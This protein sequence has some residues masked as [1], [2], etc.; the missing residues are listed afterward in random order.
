LHR[1]D[2]RLLLSA[3]GLG[4]VPVAPGTVGSFATA[5]LILAAEAGLGLGWQAAAVLFGLG[6]LATLILAGDARRPDGGTDPG[7]VVTDEV[8]G[9]SIASAA[10]LAWGLLVPALAAFF[11]FRL[12]DVLKPGYVGR[13][14]RLEGGLGVLA[15][16]LGAGVAAAAIVCLLGWSGTFAALS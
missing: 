7:W 1:R 3:L 5:A 8:A 9:Q 13:L 11:L 15:D 6:S 10:A 12:F 14:E 4:L 16:D 2:R